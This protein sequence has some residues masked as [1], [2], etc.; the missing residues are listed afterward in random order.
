[1]DLHL[2]PVPILWVLA[3]KERWRESG[4]FMSFSAQR[5]AGELPVAPAAFSQDSYGPIVLLEA[6]EKTKRG[7][8]GVSAPNVVL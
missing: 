1:M 4:L 8:V 2:L 7:V 5:T 6:S 3:Q